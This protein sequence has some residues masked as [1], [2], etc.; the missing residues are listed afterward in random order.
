MS[1]KIDYSKYTIEELLDAKTNIDRNANPE[2]YQ[3]LVKELE[4]RKIWVEEY[5]KGVEEKNIANIGKL[6]KLLGW[7]QISGALLLLVITVGSAFIKQFEAKKVLFNLLAIGLNF[8]SGYFLLK[9]SRLGI[10]LSIL[11]QT[12]QAV[13]L[14]AGSTL[15]RYLGIFGIYLWLNDKLEI[16][17]MYTFNPGFNLLTNIKSDSIIL[18]FDILAIFFICVLFRNYWRFR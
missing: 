9:K 13:S 10:Q 6:L 15:Y 18:A 17:I 1:D 2:N 7:L 16:G 12:L 3:A 8:S 4:R 11:N 14:T 5:Q